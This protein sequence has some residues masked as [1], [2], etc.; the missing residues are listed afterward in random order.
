MRKSLLWQTWDERGILW[1]NSFIHSFSVLIGFFSRTPSRLPFND[2]PCR[3]SFHDDVSLMEGKDSHDGRH[4]LRLK[5]GREKRKRPE[6]DFPW[7]LFVLKFTHWWNFVH[8][9]DL[10]DEKPSP[11]KSLALYSFIWHCNDI[12]MLP[13]LLPFSHPL[14]TQLKQNETAT[15]VRFQHKNFLLPKGI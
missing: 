3:P 1:R 11:W 5:L 6:K 8:R 10:Q 15:G 7:V 12:T 4:S 14:F 13:D 9:Q 2:N